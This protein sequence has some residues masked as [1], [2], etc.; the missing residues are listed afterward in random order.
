MKRHLF[1][2]LFIALSSSIFADNFITVFINKCVEEKKP[3]SNINIGRSML[4][5]LADKTDDEALKKAFQD[6]SSIRIVTAENTS[7]SRYYFKKAIEFSKT[8]FPEFEEV[9][10]INERKSKVSILLK[11]L[12]E[13]YQELIMIGLDEDNKLT[14]ISITGKIDFNAIS[15]LSDSIKNDK[16]ISDEIQNNENVN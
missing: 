7:D 9:V 11:K 14:I 8:E 4:A 5:K 15:K 2:I 12:D 1:I 6:L 10:S 16:D 3:I 13:N